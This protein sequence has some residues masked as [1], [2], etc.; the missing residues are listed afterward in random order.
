[1]MNR[2]SKYNMERRTYWIEVMAEID[3]YDKIKKQS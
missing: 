3:I 1:M 2:I